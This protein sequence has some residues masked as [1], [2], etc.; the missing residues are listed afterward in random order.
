M[1][2]GCTIFPLAI[3]MP[4]PGKKVVQCYIHRNGYLHLLS[5]RR[6]L[7]TRY[8]SALDT[9]ARPNPLSA[10]S[11]G[12]GQARYGHRRP[13]GSLAVRMHEVQQ[14]LDE[15]AGRKVQKYMGAL[16]C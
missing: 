3:P 9:D 1:H 6:Q 14:R 11:K 4:L 5:Q 8:V 13:R 2:L 10:L 15:S 16:C 12:R 7:E